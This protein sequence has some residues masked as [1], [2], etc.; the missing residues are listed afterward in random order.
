MPCAYLP[1]GGPVVSVAHLDLAGDHFTGRIGHIRGGRQG[2]RVGV[3]I[4]PIENGF[5][6]EGVPLIVESINHVQRQASTIAPPRS[7]ILRGY[8]IKGLR[9]HQGTRVRIHATDKAGGNQRQH[10]SFGEQRNLHLHPQTLPDPTPN[11]ASR[12]H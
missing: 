7:G 12:C 8:G 1:T 2:Q 4:I 9:S 6:K 11:E 3:A 5:V 10:V